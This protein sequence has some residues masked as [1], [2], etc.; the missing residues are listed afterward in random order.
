LVQRRFL[1]WVV[2]YGWLLTDQAHR[3]GQM[4]WHAQV[5]RV[6]RSTVSKLV[7]ITTLADGSRTMPDSR[8]VP[9]PPDS[10]WS[11]ERSIM[12][13][14]L[15]RPCFFVSISRIT[16][17]SKQWPTLPGKALMKHRNQCVILQTP[18]VDGSPCGYGGHCY[19]Q[20]CESGSTSSEIGAWYSQ[21]KNISIPVTIVGGLLVSRMSITSGVDS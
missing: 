6:L 19:N 21:N 13:R 11:A 16:I 14:D 2:S 20:T 3:V 5:G 8:T 1:G 12:C 4:G 18:L 17:S 15:S 7:I 9:W 10:L